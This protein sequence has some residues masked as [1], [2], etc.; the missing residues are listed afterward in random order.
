MYWFENWFRF[1]HA[2][3]IYLKKW[4][5]FCLGEKTLAS[6][7]Q[8]VQLI[9]LKFMSNEILWVSTNNILK[10]HLGGLTPTM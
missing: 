8:S 4:F 7:P 1:S 6:K 10:Q 9:T 3:V 2:Y 5:S